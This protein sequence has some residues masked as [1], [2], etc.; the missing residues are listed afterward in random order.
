M[1]S[2]TYSSSSS[3][4]LCCVECLD[5]YLYA[6]KACDTEGD[7]VPFG[8][9]TKEDYDDWV[10]LGLTVP[11][12]SYDG[13]TWLISSYATF[14]CD[15]EDVGP[16]E[17]AWPTAF[18]EYDY[19]CCCEGVGDG[20]S[21]IPCCVQVTGLLWDGCDCEINAGQPDWDGLMG[22]GGD[23]TVYANQGGYYDDPGF[24]YMPGL[25]CFP[26]SVLLSYDTA[27]GQW[28]LI[29][30]AS[31]DPTWA[32]TGPTDP[33]DPRGVYTYTPTSWPPGG[34]PGM[35]EEPACSGPLTLTVTDCP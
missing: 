7:P 19:A 28:F 30:T 20:F 4:C 32:G 18:F 9:G 3:S 10:A 27:L 11:A 33:C 16:I 1:S 35:P 17:G 5:Y 14:P 29:I 34:A 26:M 23:G 22:Y 6:T 15:S 25:D 2:I 31:I 12:F 13:Y 21:E 8:P 24:H